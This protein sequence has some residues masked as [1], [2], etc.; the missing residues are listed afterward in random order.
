MFVTP[1]GTTHAFWEW[2]MGLLRVD[3]RGRGQAWLL[4]LVG[5]AGLWAG[6]MAAADPSA[7]GAELWYS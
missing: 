7:M 2:P 1:G 5:W 3:G 4:F 6:A